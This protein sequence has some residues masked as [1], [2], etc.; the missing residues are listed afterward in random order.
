IVEPIQGEGGFNPIPQKYLEGLR[1]FCDE[2]GIMLIMDEVQSGFCR[3][4]YWASW[5]YY[6]V[7][8]DLSTY[9]KSM[10]SGL[11]IAAVVG[12]AEVMDAAASGS[13]GGTYIGSPVCCAASLAT[14][15]YMKEIDL[16]QK[17]MEVG[18]IIMN[19]LKSLMNHCPEIGDVRGVGAMIG[20][21]FVKNGDSRQPD[22][23]TCTKIVKGCSENGLIIL[24]AGT[25]KN[26]IR[27]L[28]PLVIT[29][30][31]LDKGMTI[32][33]NEIKKATRK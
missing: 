14:I 2:H 18:A 11:P 23:E 3:T 1:A 15:K 9:A 13:I 33:E 21:E 30:E 17:A 29:N 24:S 31:Q 32:M 6:G 12:R 25:H 27:I 8:P 20:I 16:N 5:Q 10:G 28:S 4:G 7:Q 26:I 22:A 19:R